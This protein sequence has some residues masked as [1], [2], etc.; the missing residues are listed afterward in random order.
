LTPVKISTI[1]S[2][3]HF[4]RIINRKGGRAMAK[5][6]VRQKKV[7]KKPP[8]RKKAKKM[9]RDEPFENFAKLRRRKEK[10]HGREKGRRLV[11]RLIIETVEAAVEEEAW[12]IEG[13]K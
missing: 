7:V 9:K 1:I 11:E 13:T 6:I 10:K 3:V 2:A 12:P 4:N 8:T 5:K